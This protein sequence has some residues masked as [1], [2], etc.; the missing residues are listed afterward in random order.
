[1]S[2]AVKQAIWLRHII[3]ALNKRSLLGDEAT[4]LYR[5][6]LETKTLVKKSSEH[7]QSKHIQIRYHAICDYIVKDNITIKYVSTELMLADGLTKAVDKNV[8]S[9]M[10]QAFKLDEA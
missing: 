1:M 9:R 4:I 2:K 3:T 6:N 10:I 5:D 8:F 7:K